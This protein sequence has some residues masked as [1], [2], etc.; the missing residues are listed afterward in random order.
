M[1]MLLY[2][3]LQS[4]SIEKVRSAYITNDFLNLSVRAKRNAILR[5]ISKSRKYILIPFLRNKM[6]D[7]RVQSGHFIGKFAR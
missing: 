2:Q 7:T 6:M 4:M 5:T 1:V 3:K